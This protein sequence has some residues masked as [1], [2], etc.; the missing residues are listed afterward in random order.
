MKHII[1]IL[2]LFV[3]SI[4]YSYAQTSPWEK[5]YNDLPRKERDEYYENAR[6]FLRNY[7]DQITAAIEDVEIH[8]FITEEL[9]NREETEVVRYQPEFVPERG[10]QR[11][12]TFSQYLLEASNT[13]QGKSEGLEF[14]VSNIEEDKYVH[15][16]NAQDRWIAPNEK[17]E[18][19]YSE[20]AFKRY[21]K[22]TKQGNADAQYE[23]GNC[24]YNG[25][26]VSQNDIQAIVWYVYSGTRTY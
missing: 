14:V 12:L 20:K 15:G 7:Y 11:I 24:Y 17:R 23:F 2:L 9:I 1:S 25:K 3:Y 8:P 10:K 26:G 4:G 5:V 13:F 6:H 21:A 19:N 16:Y 22:A 18:R